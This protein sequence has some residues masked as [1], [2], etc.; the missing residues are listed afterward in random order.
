MAYEVPETTFTTPKK[1]FPPSKTHP[2]FLTTDYKPLTSVL[3]LRK[4]S[5]SGFYK[6]EQR[7]SP[8]VEVSS[9]RLSLRTNPTL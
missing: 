7:V 1:G 8:L 9:P 6:E 4:R 5:W 2:L 3:T